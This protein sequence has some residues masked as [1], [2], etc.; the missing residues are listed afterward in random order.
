MKL[1]NIKI[2]QK[3]Y[4]CFVSLVIVLVAQSAVIQRLTTAV[5]VQ[6]EKIRTQSQDFIFLPSQL[7]SFNKE[8]QTIL[9]DLT[10]LIPR[11]SVDSAIR[12][13][14]EML[15]G[16]EDGFSA[17]IDAL[18]LPIE[19]Q[20]LWE[21]V[22]AQRSEIRARRA[23]W[24]DSAFSKTGIT[25]EAVDDLE[26]IT[27]L[28]RAYDADLDK[29]KEK[30]LSFNASQNAIFDAA[31]GK[32]QRIV[33]LITILIVALVS[34]AVYFVISGIK[35]PLAILTKA[36][37]DAGEGDLMLSTL[38]EKERKT[39]NDMKRAD[40]IGIMAQSLSKMLKTFS[41]TLNTVSHAALQMKHG[42]EQISAT[43]QAVSTGASEQAASTEEMS[44][45]MEQI[46]SNIKQNAENAAKTGR[47]AEKT[48]EDTK[49]GGEAV[50]KA[51]LAVREIAEKIT[52]IG[53]IASQTNLLALNAAIEAARAGEAG[54][55]FAVV[56]SEVRK[57]AE[58]SSNSADEITQLSQNTIERAE[59]ASAFIN[60]IIPNVESTAQLVD[61]IAHASREQDKG[62]EQVSTAITQLDSVVQQNASA[63]EQLAAMAQELSSNAKD[64][65][66]AVSFF[67]L[68]NDFS[69]D[70]VLSNIHESAA[71]EAFAKRA[72]QMR[73]KT[74]AMKARRKSKKAL[75]NDSH[76]EEF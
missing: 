30:C 35:S 5:R 70:T 48:S 10:I 53:E 41:A 50:D 66:K 31:I 64:L 55:G 13:D 1:N 34:V 75:H 2:G 43:S 7:A 23:K 68:E 45:T 76:F 8:L 63:S 28:A 58:R 4:I 47:I 54:K 18:D 65:V 49:T 27:L 57:L 73:E 42:C 60:D 9:Y 14:I 17:K 6:G 61:E 74:D 59:E 39:L 67:K 52:I 36:L 29:L 11:G 46:A 62:A 37:K 32:S 22:K 51:M 24:L 12:G 72:A 3:L 33:T 71:S 56:A 20:K 16:I 69:A 38:N 40:E 44:A 15:Q 21:A 26:E 25:N 19:E